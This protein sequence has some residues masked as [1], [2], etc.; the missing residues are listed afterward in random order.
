MDSP[1]PAPVRSAPPTVPGALP[2][3][4]TAWP[5]VLGI[6][7]IVF[8]AL[9]ILGCLWGLVAPFVMGGIMTGAAASGSQQDQAIAQAFRDT[10]PMQVLSSGLQLVAAV[11]LLVS[12]VGLSMR[13]RWSAKWMV[14]WAIVKMIVVLI[15]AY[16]GM[17][18]QRRMMQAA[19]PQ[20]GAPNA[21]MM[22]MFTGF[23]L[24]VMVVWGWI[25]PT[26]VLI[27][28]QRRKIKD[29][30]AGWR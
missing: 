27:W 24:L 29:E 10:A 26:F 3:P 6:I 21:A 16:L 12:G 13:R 7:G 15:A 20:T 5:T 22:S 17:L 8:G 28:F 30:V 23:G 2:P 14:I 25:L 4:R 9:A 19:S 18:V 1:A 11:L